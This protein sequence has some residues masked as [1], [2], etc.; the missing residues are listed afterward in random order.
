MFQRW[1]DTLMKSN[2]FGPSDI[3]P[4]HFERNWRFL[5]TRSPETYSVD[6]LFE[7]SRF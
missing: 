6:L 2:A 3:K 4:L 5:V 7:K 1:G